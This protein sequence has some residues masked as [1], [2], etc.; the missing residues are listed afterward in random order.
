MHLHH[1]IYYFMVGIRLLLL[2][3]FFLNYRFLNKEQKVIFIYAITNAFMGVVLDTLA[4]VFHN[5]MPFLTGM[6]LIQF[7]ILTFFYRHVLKNP[8][9]RK[10]LNIML[11]IS[12]IL[13]IVDIS[14][15]EG[16]LF[17]N[18][19]FVSFRT[20]LLIIYGVIFFLQLMKDESLI[21]QSIYINELPA[22]WFNAGLFVALC[23]AFP[24]DLCFNYLQKTPPTDYTINLFRITAALTWSGG[25]IQSILFYIGLVKLKAARK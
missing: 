10:I 5:N 12:T 11:V 19:I 4:R 18:S 9:A 25:V 1:Y 14:F 17:F 20:F 22:F 16:P 21:E 8:N 13:C 15:L 24:L 2:I 6:M 7:F 3:P 23:C